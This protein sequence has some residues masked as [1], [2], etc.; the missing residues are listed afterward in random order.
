MAPDASPHNDFADA[1][2]RLRH[3]SVPERRFGDRLIV[4]RPLDGAPVVLAAPAAFVWR[5]LDGWIS[6]HELESRV[7]TAFPEVTCEAR[8]VACAEI[9]EELGADDLVERG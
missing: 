3:R 1:L 4:A 8:R 9:I 7:A 2:D 5:Q 6:T